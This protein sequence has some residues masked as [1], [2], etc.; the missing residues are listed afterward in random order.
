MPVTLEATALCHLLA[1]L[2]AHRA[3]LELRPCHDAVDP[4]AAFV[5]RVEGIGGSAVSYS[6]GATPD[7]A[8]AHA[9]RHYAQTHPAE[10]R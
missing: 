9:A 5:C 6:F 8:L 4:R 7:E 1:L 10:V 3:G 2:Y